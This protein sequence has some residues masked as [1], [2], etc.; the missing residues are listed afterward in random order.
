M[1]ELAQV[2]A[3]KDEFSFTC[4]CWQLYLACHSWDR[5]SGSW[6]PTENTQNSC[7]KS[8]SELDPFIL[9]PS[10]PAINLHF[11]L[12]FIQ[13]S[14]SFR[15]LLA[16]PR[17]T[18]TSANIPSLI[19]LTP[20]SSPLLHGSSGAPA[21]QWSYYFFPL[22]PNFVLSSHVRPITPTTAEADT[23]LFSLRCS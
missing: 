23:L 4:H 8:V 15:Y 11:L 9:P 19:I 2:Q 1:I 7:C 13:L 21:V 22:S 14:W 16:L 10:D 17:A 3:L 5:F 20:F 18:R 12:Y 6:N